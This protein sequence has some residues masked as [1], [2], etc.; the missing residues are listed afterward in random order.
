MRKALFRLGWVVLLVLPVIYGIQI[1]IT[2]DL[3]SVEM[4]KWFIPLAAVVLIYF[5][6]NRDDVL[7]HHIIE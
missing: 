1:Y 4:W 7:R 2:Q 3:P 6:R 5:S